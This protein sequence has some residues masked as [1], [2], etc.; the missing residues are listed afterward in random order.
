MT[1]SGDFTYFLMILARMSGCVFLNQIFGSGRLPAL[2]KT[3][4]SLF[5]TITIYGLLPPSLDMTISS[6][7]E[8]SLL[9]IKEIFIGYLIGYIVSLFFSTVIIS[10]EVI[11]MQT[12]MSMASIYDPT[13]NISTGITGSFLNLILMLVFF[14]SNGH[15]TL[16]QIFITSCKLV[17]I[18]SFSIPKDLFYNMV[19][20]FQQI[21]ILS[22]KLAMPIVA[23]EI[24]LEAGI[25]ILMKA[26]PQIQVFS[27]NVQLKILAGLLLILLLVPTFSTFIEKIIIL[28]FDTVKNSL[29]T[30]IT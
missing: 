28:M 29:S 2:V 7:I 5:L 11:G 12:G 9:I 16:I 25:G 21:L 6:P 19:E 20:L 30:L 24:I 27:V 3:S 18:G 10:G 23:V 14:S 4:L 26:I 17:K 1:L 22:L 13:S 8:Y 15:L